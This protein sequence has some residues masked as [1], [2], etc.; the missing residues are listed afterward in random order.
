[1]VASLQHYRRRAVETPGL[2]SKLSHFLAS[3]LEGEQLVLK[4][5]SSHE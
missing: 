1:M 5:E 4:G 2:I 3:L